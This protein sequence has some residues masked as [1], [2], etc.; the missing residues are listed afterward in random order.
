MK[1][2]TCITI[3]YKQLLAGMGLCCMGQ[4]RQKL[5]RTWSNDETT[6]RL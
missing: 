4:A 6:M 3:F 2:K 5:L 1:A